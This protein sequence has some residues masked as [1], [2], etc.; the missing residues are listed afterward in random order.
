MPIVDKT[1]GPHWDQ[2]Q[3]LPI[4]NEV[5]AYNSDTGMYSVN[6]TTMT[7]FCSSAELLSQSYEAV[8]SGVGPISTVSTFTLSNPAVVPATPVQTT[9]VAANPAPTQ[10]VQP[11]EHAI[12]NLYSLRDTDDFYRAFWVAEGNSLATYNRQTAEQLFLDRMNQAI[13]ANVY[14]LASSEG[15]TFITTSAGQSPELESAVI[16]TIQ[17]ST[18]SIV[19]TYN[20][21]ETALPILLQSQQALY[22]NT[23]TE[24]GAELMGYLYALQF[25]Q[26]AEANG[27][28]LPASAYEN[29]D[30]NLKTN[31]FLNEQGGETHFLET[32]KYQLAQMLIDAPDEYWQQLGFS[33][34]SKYMTEAEVM[35]LLDAQMG[36]EASLDDWMTYINGVS[37]GYGDWLTTINPLDFIINPEWAQDAARNVAGMSEAYEA[38]AAWDILRQTVYDPSWSP[39]QE[40]QLLD[41][42]LKQI[43]LLPDAIL[44]VDVRFVRAGLLGYYALMRNF[45]NW[46][47]K[48]KAVVDEVEVQLLNQ[49][50]DQ[51]HFVQAL[52][53]VFAVGSI[54][55]SIFFEPF[56]WIMSIAD[57]L[58]GDLSGVLFNLLP[59]IPGAIGKLGRFISKAPGIAADLAAK[60]ASRLD[61]AKTAISHLNNLAD[62]ARVNADDTNVFAD[63]FKTT[64]IYETKQPLILDYNYNMPE[65]SC[66]AG[67]GLLLLDTTGLNG[68]VLFPKQGDAALLWDT[69]FTNPEKVH[70][71]IQQQGT[72]SVSDLERYLRQIAVMSKNDIYEKLSSGRTT[73][74]GLKSLI[75]TGYPA[76]V[77]L[78]NPTNN[79]IHAVIIDTIFTSTDDTGQTVMRIAI[80]DMD[81]LSPHTGSY[82]ITLEEFTQFWGIATPSRLFESSPYANPL[83]PRF[84]SGVVWGEAMGFALEPF[85]NFPPEWGGK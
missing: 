82:S 66:V 29:Y 80:R 77:P 39:A 59:L 11:S 28:V 20:S 5:V 25:V 16:K 32:T 36:T 53:A 85:A 52:T 9:G 72:H 10:A 33:G 31:Q 47:V 22:G 55:L 30:P 61:E 54:A 26:A 78:K 4:A 19:P 56:D 45:H 15:Y 41:E 70:E 6:A 84:V 74:G 46:R 51:E 71:I 75:S 7:R 8:M 3:N 43:G 81:Y 62:K 50:T 69:Y 48:M 83:D 57:V 34:S 14:M 73:L 35:A 44:G 68:K 79:H 12:P 2:I 40:R 1:Q 37:Q 49:P 38:A 58:R 13:T 23:I 27:G 21:L 64:Q 24:E 63:A 17:S 67:C 76:V 18:Q 42:L 60:W 65:N